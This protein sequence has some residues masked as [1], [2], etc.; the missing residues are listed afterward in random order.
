M[1]PIH[2]KDLRVGMGGLGVSPPPIS[3]EPRK[4]LRPD[5][6]KLVTVHTKYPSDSPSF[7]TEALYQML[8]FVGVQ[9]AFLRAPLGPAVAGSVHAPW[10]SA[11]ALTEEMLAVKWAERSSQE[12]TPQKRRPKPR[13]TRTR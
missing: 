13:G 10:R 11:G 12:L 1:K 2:V 7:V 4:A 5:G 6:S 3:G 9:S 8:S